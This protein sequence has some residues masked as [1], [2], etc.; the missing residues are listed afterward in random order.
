MITQ[1]QKLDLDLEVISATPYN[2]AEKER[3]QLSHLTA[4]QLAVG[5]ADGFI[6]H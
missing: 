1:V 6:A 4:Q 2:I 3:L 5:P